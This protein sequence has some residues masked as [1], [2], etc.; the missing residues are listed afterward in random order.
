MWYSSFMELGPLDPRTCYQA[1]RTRD[2]RFD[3]RFYTGVTSTRVF[4]R[5]VCPART[6]RLQNCR[7]FTCAAAAQEAG[8]R[9]CLR[10]RP[11]S[12]PGTPPW[13]G[14]S[15]TV[16]RALRLIGEGRFDPGNIPEL[17][18]RLGV[19]D[20]HL[21][22]L[23]VRHLGASPHAVVH[24][25]RVLFA[26]KLLDETHLPMARVALAAGFSSL[27]RFNDAMRA[28]YGRPPSAL[29]HARSGAAA[30]PDLTFRIAYRPPLDWPALL[31]FLEARAIPGVE[32]VDGDLYRRAVRLPMGG[33]I[34]E[35]EHAAQSHEI[36]ATLR[37]PSPPSQL[38]DCV[39]RVRRLFDLSADPLALA[40]QL[41]D[42]AI[43]GSLFAT[44]PGIR[45]P[46]AWDGFEIA[47]RAVLGQQVSVRAARTFAAR[48]VARHGE[49]LA[50]P[51]ETVR[52]LF[53]KPEALAGADLAS[54]GLTQ[55]RAR[56][57]SALSAAVA[58]GRV[59]LDGTAD[60]ASTLHALH[61]MPGIGTWTM[62]YI[63]LR[64]LG[65]TDAFPSSDLGL[66]RGYAR[67][68]AS[69][70][71]K[72]RAVRPRTTGHRRA[73]ARREPPQAPGRIP[74][75]SE[76]EHVSEAWRPWRAYAAIQ[77][78]TWEAEHAAVDR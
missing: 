48:I 33:G 59:L 42:D 64:A 3:G 36:I 32:E 50:H 40:A 51:T 56:T 26:K 28:T 29:R 27:R 52:T 54:I 22:R 69:A 45:I 49:P 17:A 57:L 63:A 76:L 73:R 14:T 15:T 67:W 12:A 70:D 13:H 37:A 9:P 77:L 1:L 66:R 8:F 61:D 7:F 2:A 41:A 44:R 74:T 24:A 23:F 46:G 35:V 47:V 53:P 72:T 31:A 34:L 20:R 19:G 4:C 21:R 58:S 68:L 25:Q 62:Q 5:P 11:E 43:L 55:A 10:C 18:V 39:V 16:A 38:L 65:E 60:P 71:G 75:A 6:P 30:T 78:W